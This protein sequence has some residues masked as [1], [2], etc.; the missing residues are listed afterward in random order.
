ME[1]NSEDGFWQLKSLYA[2]AMTMKTNSIISHE[3]QKQ[4]SFNFIA[5]FD[6][7]F[8]LFL[9]PPIVLNLSLG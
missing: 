4:C 1:F 6:C 9:A 8:P 7:S 2:F 3:I 5:L